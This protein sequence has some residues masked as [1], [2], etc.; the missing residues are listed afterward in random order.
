MNTITIA[1]K[2]TDCNDDSTEYS[3]FWITDSLIIDM[4]NID[5]KTEE[6]INAILAMYDF[7]LYD[8]ILNHI[9]EY[10]CCCNIDDDTWK[11]SNLSILV[12]D[13]LIKV[14]KDIKAIGVD[15]QLD[16][17]TYD[18]LDGMLPLIK[19]QDINCEWAKNI[20]KLYLGKF[21]YKSA[22]W[23]YDPEEKE[24]IEQGITVYNA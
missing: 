17:Y 15:V 18:F 1:F 21:I 24:I 9:F 19:I 23:K 8:T 7:E 2:F 12:R 11:E 13:R 20:D 22:D 10:N 14:Y 4:R 6:K 5:K 16:R 3:N